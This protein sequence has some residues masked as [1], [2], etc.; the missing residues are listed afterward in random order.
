[1]RKLMNSRDLSL[2]GSKGARAFTLLVLLEPSPPDEFEHSKRNSNGT[3]AV[4]FV[5]AVCTK[6]PKVPSR[7]DVGRASD[8]GLSNGARRR[9]RM[10]ARGDS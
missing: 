3:I 6:K 1:M 4:D 8:V 9:R 7:V 10:I 2:V 5:D